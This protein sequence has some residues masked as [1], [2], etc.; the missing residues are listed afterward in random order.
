MRPRTKEEQKAYF[1]GYEMCAECIEEY[2]TDEGKEMLDC[3]LETVRS[4]FEEDESED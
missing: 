3:L 2:L 1:D 4:V